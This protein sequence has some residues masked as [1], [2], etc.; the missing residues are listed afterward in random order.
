MDAVILKHNIDSAFISHVEQKHED[1]KFMRI[2]ADVTDSL[3]EDVS[4]EDLKETK[5]TLTE[6]FRKALGKEKLEVKVEKL[7]NE[8]ISSVMIL[9]EESRR[10]QDMMKMYGMPGMDPTMFGGDQTLV[11]N[12]NNQ[13]VQY[14]CQNKESENVPVICEQLYDLAML[15]HKQ[16]SPDEMTK[17]ITRSNEILAMIAK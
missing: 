16:L 6:V 1:V 3:K 12:A 17:F 4:E 13:L 14:I 7:K 2:D 10:M 15:S 11:L 5:E 8:N 9:S